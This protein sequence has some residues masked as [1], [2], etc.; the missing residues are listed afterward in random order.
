MWEQMQQW[1]EQLSQT[2]DDAVRKDL[3]TKVAVGLM[4]EVPRHSRYLLG[5]FFEKDFKNYDPAKG[6]FKNYVLKVLKNRR[7]DQRHED[8]GSHR[9]NVVQED[10]TTKQEWIDNTSLDVY[11]DE[12]A[13]TTWKE[14]L[15]G[16]SIHTPDEML[17][18]QQTALQLITI[19]LQ[20][21][22]RL[23]GQANNPEKINYYRLFFTDGV[24]SSVY[25]VGGDIYIAHERDL[26]EAMKLPFL[27]F[28]MAEV[29]R[30]VH[31]IY[32]GKLKPYGAMV[33]G[34]PMSEPKQ[35][36]PNDVYTTYLD[37]EENRQVKASA[38]SNQR[39]AY[40][41]FLKEQLC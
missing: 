34:A 14:R 9:K 41:A 21:P 18:A 22:Q 5:R 26:F 19:I 4:Q 12:D 35:P 16:P 10:G 20:L 8:L 17:I 31:E 2:E 3:Q 15:S 30:S 6:N 33:E 36:L 24:V 37:K 25:A 1:M 28:F 40:L 32:E 23:R 11:E 27:D 39:T 29:C 38:L 7:E 13:T